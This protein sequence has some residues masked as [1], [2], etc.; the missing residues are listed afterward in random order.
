[1]FFDVMPGDRIEADLVCIEVVRKSGRAT[2]LMVT[3][4]RSAHVA[5]V[6]AKQNHHDDAMGVAVCEPSIAR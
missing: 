3:A 6:T 4:P 1:M 2:R 5:S